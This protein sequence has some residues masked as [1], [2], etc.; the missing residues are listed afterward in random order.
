MTRRGRFLKLCLLILT[1]VTVVDS[2]FAEGGAI[3]PA[4]G[5]TIEEYSREIKERLIPKRMQEAEQREEEVKQLFERS[6]DSASRWENFNGADSTIVAQTIIKDTEEITG[7]S[8][9]QCQSSNY[10]HSYPQILSPPT[11]TGWPCTI[12]YMYP[13]IPS[14]IAWRYDSCGFPCFCCGR[15][16]DVVDYY[17]P[18]AKLDSSEQM[19]QS[20]YLDKSLVEGFI[21]P[22]NEMILQDLH[23]S[24]VG[25]LLLQQSIARTNLAARGIIAEGPARIASDDIGREYMLAREALKGGP[26]DAVLHTSPD[27]TNIYTRNLSEPVNLATSSY[28]WIP[29]LAKSHEFGSDMPI[30]LIYSKSLTFSGLLDKLMPKYTQFIQPGGAGACVGH[31]IDTNKSPRDIG[32]ST[33]R[34]NDDLC[35]TR[36][37]ER[38]PLVESG[39]LNITDRTYRG[40]AKDLDL[41]YALVQGGQISDATSYIEK[42]D[43]LLVLRNEALKEEAVGCAPLPNIVDYN[44]SYDKSNIK[45]SMKGGNN[46]HEVFTA[47]RGAWGLKGVD[48]SYFLCGGDCPS[49]GMC[50]CPRGIILFASPSNPHGAEP[51]PRCPA[52]RIK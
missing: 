41:F 38:F 32:F 6:Q 3:D 23:N 40:L 48:H 50:P 18:T 33:P 35:L 20:L 13:G 5:R 47:F 52:F 31:N 10:R 21:K 44:I 46:T 16:F 17:Y 2:V 24:V 37:G 28:W 11:K 42:V 27:Q 14:G 1:T 15:I 51:L 7:S 45:E 26:L 8:F 34:R 36:M 43:K 9:L 25:D 39:R 12:K 4:N 22:E 19:Y 30:G 49:A 29:H